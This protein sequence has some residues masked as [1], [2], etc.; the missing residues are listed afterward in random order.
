LNYIR[1]HT[2]KTIANLPVIAMS[3]HVFTEEVDYYL[4]AGMN[5]FL[6]KPFSLE[7]LEHAIIEAISGHEVVI[8]N[9]S[10]P[11]EQ[12][13]INPFDT[14]VVE[15][16]ISRLGL[17]S[18]EG[19]ANLFFQSA[20]QLKAELTE[21]MEQGDFDEMA[22]LAHRMNGA[23]GNFGMQRLCALLARIETQANHGTKLTA[24]LI[25][26]FQI[27]FDEASAALSSFL[28][29]QKAQPQDLSA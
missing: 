25:E 2:D 24:A 6:G 11:G 22:N 16:D 4:C 9:T 5:G 3:A 15:N 10:Q 7:D 12:S 29:Q 26:Q 21:A 18:V 20:E 13:K 8:T 19:Y 28:S 27:E 14:S 17:D 23:A 1:T